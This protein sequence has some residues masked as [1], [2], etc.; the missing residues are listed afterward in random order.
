MTKRPASEIPRE[1]EF[2][3]FST[4][5]AEAPRTFT[6]AAEIA[7]RLV[8]DEALFKGTFG[9][10]LKDIANDLG[11]SEPTQEELQSIRDKDNIRCK[12]H[13]TGHPGAYMRCD[14]NS[15]DIFINEQ[16]HLFLH[17]D[18]CT[19]NDLICDN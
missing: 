18:D 11:L 2:F 9:E 7:S 8:Q 19:Q 3:D 12:V 17:F 14:S 16:V 6:H 5:K 13:L 1:K 15:D 10:V 4:L